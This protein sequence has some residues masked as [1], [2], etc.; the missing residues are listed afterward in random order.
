MKES[1]KL[2]EKM[3]RKANEKIEAENQKQEKRN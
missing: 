2:M 3:E 1:I